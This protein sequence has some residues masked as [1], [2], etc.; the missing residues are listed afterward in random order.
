MTPR[1]RGEYMGTDTTE[2]SNGNVHASVTCENQESTEIGVTSNS[3]GDMPVFMPCRMLRECSKIDITDESNGNISTAKENSY[4][5]VS[6]DASGEGLPY[7]PENF[8]LPGDKWRWRVGKRVAVTGDYKDRYLYLPKRLRC[9]DQSFRYTFASKL[10]VERYIRTAFPNA[11]VDEFFASF[12]WKIPSKNLLLPSGVVERRPFFTAHHEEIGDHSQSDSPSGTLRCKA[13][14]KLCSSLI[15]QPEEA[16]RTSI[17]CDFCCIEPEFCRDCC[18]ILCFKVIMP[19]NG[20]YNYIKCEAS[21]NDGHIC[22]HLAHLNCALQAYMAGTVGGSIGLDAQYY[23]RR[24]DAKTELVSH[25][26]RLFEACKS[27]DSQEEHEKA[28]KLGSCLLQGSLNTSA[29]ILLNRIQS[30]LTKLKCGIHLETASTDESKSVVSSNGDPSLEGAPYRDALD[31]RT[32]ILLDE[33]ISFDLQT[34]SVQLDDEID[35]IL[36]SEKVSGVGIQSSR[37]TA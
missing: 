9:R 15:E 20:G 16:A 22:G 21:S 28:L 24:C 29:K 6:C 17:P 2:E 12:S 27:I 30:A 7:A 1:W 34:P 4:L 14:N 25:V 23:C 32:H 10:S 18:C 31:F 35:Q 36:R 13:R 33:S 37:G 8:P 3:N 26:T 19:V 11:D 5:P